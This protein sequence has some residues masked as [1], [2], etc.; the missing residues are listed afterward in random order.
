M[1]FIHHPFNYYLE[2]D[3]SKKKKKNRLCYSTGQILPE[4]K[5]ITLCGVS[6]VMQD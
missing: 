3:F 1:A 6:E 2:K 5:Q 4:K